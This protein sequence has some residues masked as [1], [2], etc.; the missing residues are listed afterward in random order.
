MNSIFSIIKNSQKISILK[1]NN[2]R[3]FNFKLMLGIIL[4]VYAII[5][6]IL[7]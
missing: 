7:A 6:H 3:L 4:N 2:W 5:L 1:D